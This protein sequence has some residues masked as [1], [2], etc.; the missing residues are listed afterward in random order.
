[1]DSKKI[2]LL[3]LFITFFKG[4][5]FAVIVPIWHTPDE[6]AHFA[7]V[8]FFSEFN[9]MPRF[10]KDLNR[11]IYESEK[12]LGTLR[13][14][15]GNNKFTFHPEYRIEYTNSQVGKY[16]NKILNLSKNYRTNLV[17]YEAANY[18]PLY[19]WISSLGYK[20]FYDEDLITRIYAARIISISLGVL[21]IFI[22]WKIAKLIFPNQELLQITLP[23][24]VSFQPMFSFV[25]A[26]VNSD[27]LMNLLFS[28]LIYLSILIINFSL[29]IKYLLFSIITILLLY[30]TK[31][32]VIL[33]LPILLLAIII[34]VL[35]SKKISTYIKV[36][37]V[38]TPIIL[39]G[40]GYWLFIERGN[41][42]L[43]EKFYT[44]S[45]Y[46]EK[47]KIQLNP[48]AFFRQSIAQTI[49]EALPWY[50]GVFNWL[51]VT[52][53]IL[54]N[55]II[56]RILIIAAIGILVKLFFSIKNRSKQEIMFIYL[57][58]VSLIYFLGLTFYNY[59]FTANHGFP[60]GIQGRYYFPTIIAHMAILLMGIISLVPNK[61][62]KLQY[63]LAKALSLGMIVLNFITLWVIAKSY[64]NLSS[65]NSF[66]IQLSQYKPLVFKTPFITIILFAYCA[67][68][69]YF[70]LSLRK[71]EKLSR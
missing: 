57:I 5:I 45:F 29:K 51:G 62:I 25:S 24:L 66:I 1:M 67:L 68:V 41:S 35:L 58:A 44:Q 47:P 64:Y 56:N 8:A 7:Q 48:I 11:E 15:N 54:V 50:W 22:A 27:N 9:K 10:T 19:Y 20:F 42:L 21:T 53:P 37:S 59:L 39:L 70:I 71:L 49:A 6:Q 14:R 23:A 34:S 16:E 32:Q 4:L 55:R 30:L 31:P 38:L 3:L 33:A 36:L 61:F 12:L 52:L 65:Y 63:S 13:D 43:L 17:K 18:P 2:I 60:F 28:L 40:F 26:G 46:P 69:V